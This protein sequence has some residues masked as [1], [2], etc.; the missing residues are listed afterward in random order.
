MI[1]LGNSVCLSR[2]CLCF[3]LSGTFVKAEESGRALTPRRITVADAIEMTQWADR[4]Y[5]AGGSSAGRVGVFSP[6]GS[7]FV[8][9]LEKG[10][11]TS[12]TNEFSILL[13]DAKPSLETAKPQLLV[14]M[15]SSS[16]RDGIKNV[17]W[18][19]DNETIVF[20]GENPGETPQI[21]RLNIKSRK[22]K[23]LTT[24]PTAIVAYDI[25]RSGEQIVFEAH[26]PL[27]KKVDTAE[28]RRNGLVITGGYPDNILTEDC[29]TERADRSEQ[30]YVQGRDGVAS[31]IAT[32]DFL[33]DWEPLSM[34]PNGRFAL[35]PVYLKD[36]P[37]R[38][39]QYQDDVLHRYVIEDRKVGEYSN[40]R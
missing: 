2:A 7:R 4:N 34:A 5:A 29:S 17:K 25:S 30:L 38:W 12:N 18:L 22:L 23:K 33:S 28:V 9:V 8:V 24:H 11:L 26:P 27:V 21:Y 20:L 37:Q 14:K 36:V 40:V 35:L 10:N 1:Q 19:S 39:D 31:Q 16:N 32:N 13:F 3:L 15:A 6:D